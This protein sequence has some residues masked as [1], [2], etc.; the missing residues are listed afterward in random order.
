TLRAYVSRG[1]QQ[2]AR[3]LPLNF[4]APLLHI[5]ITIIYGRASQRSGSETHDRRARG[6]IVQARIGDSDTAEGRSRVG[7]D[8]LLQRPHGGGVVE[9]SVA[10]TN[11]RFA[12]TER[13]PGEAEARR[14][15]QVPLDAHGVAETRILATLNDAIEGIPS[16][17]DAIPCSR[18]DLECLGRI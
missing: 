4:Q 12:V 14:E 5:G 9:D 15:I 6:R 13:I 2:I 3:Q 11:G 10:A 1:N 7:P 17:G 16:V 8:V 18:I